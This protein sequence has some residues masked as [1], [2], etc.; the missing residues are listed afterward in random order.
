[1]GFVWVGGVCNGCAGK[2]MEGSN[3]RITKI[4]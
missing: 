2:E 4:D 3:E 1:V